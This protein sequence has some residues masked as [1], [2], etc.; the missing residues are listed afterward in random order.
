MQLQNESLSQKKRGEVG[1]GM[2]EANKLADL[3]EHSCDPETREV[4]EG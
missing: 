3:M 1:G 2:G 4:E